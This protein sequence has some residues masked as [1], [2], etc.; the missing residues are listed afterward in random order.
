[1]LMSDE[2][3]SFYPTIK[4]NTT[5]FVRYYLDHFEKID[6]AF[7]LRYA[8][9]EQIL[10]DDKHFLLYIMNGLKTVMLLSCITWTVGHVY[11]MD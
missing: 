5:N 11:S 4:D 3:L 10:M 2:L 7:Y 1:M 6:R 8:S 9:C